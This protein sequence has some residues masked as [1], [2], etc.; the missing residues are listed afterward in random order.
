MSD[1]ERWESDPPPPSLGVL[2]V[3]V[4]GGLASVAV[5]AALI[6]GACALVSCALY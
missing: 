5:W 3:W 2:L 4:C 1:W 6:V